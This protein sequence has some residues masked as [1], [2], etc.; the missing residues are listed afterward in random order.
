MSVE[1][2]PYCGKPFKRLKAHLPYCKMAP[3]SQ[4]KK[5]IQMPKE[6]SVTTPKQKI[7]KNRAITER[8]KV[9]V[10]EKQ[11]SDGKREEDR[12]GINI[13]L[14]ENANS[15]LATAEVKVTSAETLNKERLKSK[16]LIKRQ[17]EI[18]RS[19]QLVPVLQKSKNPTSIS[20][21]GGDKS[22][23]EISKEPTQGPSQS[24]GKTTK[25]KKKLKLT[26]LSGQL[27]ITKSREKVSE[28]VPA[29][30]KNVSLPDEWSLQHEIPKL[31]T[32][33]K[34]LGE[35]ECLSNSLSK[36]SAKV[37]RVKEQ[38]ALPLFTSKT[39]VWEH[40]NESLY[41]RRANNVSLPYPIIEA[42]KDFAFETKDIS[43]TVQHLNKLEAVAANVAS[44]PLLSSFETSIQ[45]PV[46]DVL[47]SRLSLAWNPE[48]VTAY[49]RI[50]FSAVP[51]GSYSNENMWMKN[52]VSVPSHH[53]EVPLVEQKLGD[54][55]L[56]ELGDWFGVQIPKSPREIVTILNQGWQWYYRKYI[57]VRRGG[58]GGISM[59][60]AGY[61]VLS[62][63]W[64]YPHLSKILC[65]KK[66]KCTIE[67]SLYFLPSN[68]HKTFFVLQR[69]N[70]GGS[71]IKDP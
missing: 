18:E 36:D 53:I 8:T 55:R 66:K 13:K 59:L 14:I 22:F 65:L 41:F 9:I 4:P 25:G 47:S 31:R 60:F 51:L 70:A 69:K 33:V 71:T 61:C 62:Y 56:N 30:L 19:Q 32:I 50:L 2:C 63:I 28:L 15:P 20:K 1:E 54:V 45:R 10:D 68:V 29:N 3:V 16:W 39:S 42:P 12:L 44:T 24:N 23:H 38:K 57:N 48:I 17:K 27:S 67:I 58:I 49:N 21:H 7:H 52:W 35:L 37:S 11:T 40:I 64:N 26:T 34:Y 43:D 5:S 6:L 46:K